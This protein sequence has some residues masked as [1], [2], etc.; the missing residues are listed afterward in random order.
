MVRWKNDAYYL[1]DL[2]SANGTF[3]NGKE[4][5]STGIR[6]E[7]RDKVVLADEAFEFKLE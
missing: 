7:N 4:I 6:L 5:D 3:V 1:F 2:N